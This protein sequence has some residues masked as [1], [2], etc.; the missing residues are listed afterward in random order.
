MRRFDSDP[1]LHHFNHLEQ[2]RKNWLR[3]GIADVVVQ[4][5]HGEGALRSHNLAAIRS[6]TLCDG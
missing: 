1:R 3:F 2:Q 4:V 5:D 6:R